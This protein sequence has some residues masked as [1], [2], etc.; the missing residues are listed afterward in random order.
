MGVN[1]ADTYRKSMVQKGLI[2][3]II[4]EIKGAVK[5]KIFRKSS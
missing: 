1:L 4:G 5:P 3:E 2:T